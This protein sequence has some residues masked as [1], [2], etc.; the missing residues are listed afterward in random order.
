MAAMT[1]PLRM[2]GYFFND[3]SSIVSA[4]AP[5]NHCH[6]AITGYTPFSSDVVDNVAPIL[7]HMSLIVLGKNCAKNERV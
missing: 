6:Y 7:Q 1:S 4:I 5:F 2:P 3:L